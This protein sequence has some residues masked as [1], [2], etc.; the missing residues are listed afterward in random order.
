MIASN[1]RTIPISGPKKAMN[2]IR[3]KSFPEE[4]KSIRKTKVGLATSFSSSFSPV[5]TMKAVTRLTMR[6]R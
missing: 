1:P 5:P 4:V 3:E 6:I 2:W